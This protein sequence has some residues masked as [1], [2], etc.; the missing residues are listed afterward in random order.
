MDTLD[1][2]KNEADG[3]D[4]K[5]AAL[6]AKRLDIVK[7]SAEYMKRHG[8]K[9]DNRGRSIEK[10]DAGDSETAEYLEGLKTYIVNAAGRYHIK[11]M[12]DK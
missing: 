7:K 3:I 8:I 5:I 12:K 6:F 10:S 4:K 11:I 1:K 2:W 9:A